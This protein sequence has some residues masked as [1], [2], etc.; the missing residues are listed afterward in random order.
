MQSDKR[1][2]VEAEVADVLY[3]LLRFSQMNDIDL[4]SSLIKKIKKNNVNYPIEKAK[5]S[6]KKYDE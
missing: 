3:F 6:N 5:G 1:T 2:S 4:A